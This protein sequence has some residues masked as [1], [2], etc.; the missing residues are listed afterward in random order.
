MSDTET[1]LY[2]YSWDK[3]DLRSYP[4]S[5]YY[6]YQPEILDYLQHVIERHDLGKH[7]RFNTES[8]GHKRLLAELPEDV[9]NL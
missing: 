9:C 4:W 6:I 3:N 8:M 1:Y 2:R 5:S 7:M